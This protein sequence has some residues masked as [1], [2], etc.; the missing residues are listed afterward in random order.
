MLAVIPMP[1][2]DDQRLSRDYTVAPA[3]N[4][5]GTPGAT[6]ITADGGLIPYAEAAR[7]LVIEQ[8]SA[9]IMAMLR[10]LFSP[11]RTQRVDQQTVAV[12]LYVDEYQRLIT[13]INRA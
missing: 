3:M 8:R 13:T 7:L 4:E 9:T 12:F 2:D 5:D 10:D 6:I 11:Q 1:D